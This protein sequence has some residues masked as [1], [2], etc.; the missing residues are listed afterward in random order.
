M[1]GWV[2]L[3]YFLKMFLSPSWDLGG[4]DIS[5]IS[6][7]QEIS[8]HRGNSNCS[9]TTTEFFSP[10]L[11]LYFQKSW[12]DFCMYFSLWLNRF[13]TNTSEIFF[14]CSLILSTENSQQCLFH[15][16][17]IS[18]GCQGTGVTLDFPSIS[19]ILDAVGH[20]STNVIRWWK[21]TQQPC[22]STLLPFP[23][24]PC[25]GVCIRIILTLSNA[26]AEPLLRALLCVSNLPLP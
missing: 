17:C 4:T 15:C 14:Y 3:E 18:S 19:W 23:L 11:N 16:E 10:E 12:Q 24:L 6:V 8:A 1:T 22:K 26:A 13:S 7:R 21:S 5:R 20:H 9:E 2:C 25:S